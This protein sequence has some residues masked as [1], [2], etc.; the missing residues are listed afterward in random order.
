MKKYIVIGAV[1]AAGLVQADIAPVVNQAKIAGGTAADSNANPTGNFDIKEGGGAYSRYAVMKI[2]LSGVSGT[3]DSATFTMKIKDQAAGNLRVFGVVDSAAN[4]W[5]WN[6]DMTWNE[7]G[8]QG[9]WAP[10]T[11]LYANG[12]SDPNLVDLG[13]Y[14]TVN[15]GSYPNVDFTDPGLV[16]LVNNDTDG[17]LTVF[18]A[19]D[20]NA[21]L[22]IREGMT[23]A[24]LTYSVIPEPA[25]LGL[26]AVAAVG[27]LGVR[28][29][30]AL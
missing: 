19:F 3:V 12:L 7:A 2:D 29:F 10:T 18:A 23:N 1:L 8:V 9:M 26:V 27:M 13:T 15:N 5:N 16:T 28:R 17:M 25:T 4:G 21:N 6:T 22:G 14:T 24:S 11:G 30:L 20:A